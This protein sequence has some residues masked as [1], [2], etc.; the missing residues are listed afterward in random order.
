MDVDGDSAE[1]N[2]SFFFKHMPQEDARHIIQ[3]AKTIDIIQYKFLG[4]ICHHIR[5]GQA[6]GQRDGRTGGNAFGAS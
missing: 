1:A 3:S 6:D 5:V 4:G 2:G